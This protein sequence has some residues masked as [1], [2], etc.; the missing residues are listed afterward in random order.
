MALGAAETVDPTPAPDPTVA[1]L[2]PASPSVGLGRALLGIAA[3]ATALG[4]A[5][6]FA[7]QPLAS[8]QLLPRLGGSA[9]VW[10]T[11]LVFFQAVLLLG[12]LLTH[13]TTRLL[14]PAQ[15]AVV[16]LAV[17]AT[18]LLVLPVGVPSSWEPPTSGSPVW[19]QLGVLTRTVG[20]AYLAVATT[21]PLVQRWLSLSTHQRA[22]D[23]YV[24]YAVSNV[25]S[26]V[27]LLALPLWFDRSFAIADQA[28]LWAIGYGLFVASCIALVTIIRP[29]HAN[30]A[31]EA[32]LVVGVAE[33]RPDGVRLLRWVALAFVPSSLILGVTTHI[34]TDVASV[35]LLWVV[36]LGLYLLTHVVAFSDRSIPRRLRD[37]LAA[38]AVAATVTSTIVEYQAFPWNLAP[39]FAVLFFVGLACHG[40]LA[41][42]RPGAEHLT[43]FYLALSMGGLAGGM[44]N[45][46]VAPLA[47]DMVVEYP[48][49]L[50]ASLLLLRRHRL[51]L[52][53]RPVLLARRA[54]LAVVCAAVVAAAAVA[55]VRAV[56]THPGH[57]LALVV[58]ATALATAA[59]RS[60]T[61]AT[62]VGTV[63][64][65]A[66]RDLGATAVVTE[67]GFYGA[68][69]VEESDGFRN[70]THGTT[71]H[72]Y[73][74]LAEDRRHLVTSYYGPPGPLSQVVSALRAEDG[75]LGRIGVIGLGIG[76]IAGFLRPGDAATFYEIDPIVV[77]LAEDRSLFS[78]LSESSAPVRIV[79]GD[80]RRNIDRAPGGFELI[81]V[82][83]FSSDAIPVHLLT[84]EAVRIYQRKLAADGVIAIHISNRYLDLEPVVGAI[85]DELGLVARTGSL[86]ESEDDAEAGIAGSEWVMLARDRSL[87]DT[88][89]EP[90]WSDAETRP[91]VRAWTDDRADLFG[92]LVH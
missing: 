6:G 73:Q 36:P 91:S 27:G 39:H 31:A 44:F 50:V 52:R 61:A 54:V 29:H 26:F 82:D 11:T 34:T 83:A 32:A 1:P 80:G 79:V 37:V 10:N 38:A 88:L 63:A 75:Q 51:D 77:R 25:G 16:H 67:R 46:V 8:R 48:I 42:E 72:G 21:S 9:A 22:R 35:P 64:I 4:A 85:A 66:V 70:L 19:W 18:G 7:V 90:I 68:I 62:L 76:T 78:Y 15:Q 89:T 14:R 23:P 47:F 28:R 58:V 3:V 69:R 41:D 87:L 55:A 92:V 12:Y 86:A 49:A 57:T 65:L 60:L 17:L 24:L 43:L 74:F 5:L 30:D 71:V 53:V 2:P 56:E 81:V 45:A 33:P 13:I 20:P 59:G 40:R 84:V